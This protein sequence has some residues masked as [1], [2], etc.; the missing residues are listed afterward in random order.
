VIL[1]REKREGYSREK[2]RYP[3]VGQ[4]RYEVNERPQLVIDYLEA[5]RKALK[6]QEGIT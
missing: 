4:Y 6:N 3:V 2:L 5:Y 1:S